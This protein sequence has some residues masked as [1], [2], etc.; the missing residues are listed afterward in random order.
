MYTTIFHVSC[1]E[2]AP[3]FYYLRESKCQVSIVKTLNLQDGFQIVAGFDLMTGV[4]VLIC[5]CHPSIS[6]H[7]NEAVE[8]Y[9]E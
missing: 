5:K 6:N 3:L 9:V 1:D 8:T 4:I 7:E 2:V